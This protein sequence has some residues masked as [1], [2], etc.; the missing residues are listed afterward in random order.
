MIMSMSPSTQSVSIRTTIRLRTAVTA[1]AATLWLAG[2]ALPL[3]HPGTSVELPQSWNETS[4]SHTDALALEKEWWQRYGSDELVG[5]VDMALAGSPDL[6]VATERV[7]QAEIALRSAGAT[8]FPSID[9]TASTTGRNTQS[10]SSSITDKSSSLALGISY[11][12]DIWGTNLLNREAAHWQLT[13]TRYDY[14]ATRLS[15]VAGVVNAYT[16]L[17]SQRE[18]L[19]IARDNLDIAE[20]LFKI[21]EARFRFGAAS[22]L[23]VS[24]QHMTVLSQR[25]ALI[26]MEEQEKQYRRALAILLGQVPQQFDVAGDTIDPLDIPDISVVF[27]FELLTRR[28]DLAAEEARLAASDANIEIARAALFPLKFSL[29]A[30][31]GASSTDFALLGL[32][33]PITTS[34]LTISIIQNIF[35]GGRLRGQVETNESQRRQLVE[36]YR[37]TALTALKEVDDAYAAAAR[38]EAQEMSQ[39]AILAEAE[40]T[41]RLSE[42]RYREGSDTLTTLLDAQRSLF[43]VRDQLVQSRL[44]RLNASVDLYKALGGG[45]QAADLPGT[46]SR[47]EAVRDTSAG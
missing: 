26:P 14:E 19:A 2:C 21:V 40:R 37:K 10:S 28:P 8:L 29:G 23:D 7:V 6:A 45:W 41:L 27:P 24:R 11:E 12:I 18:R 36:T 25:D 13:A 1:L 17:L 16:Q 15:L 20:R 5:L 35:D 42:L 38:S 31:I 30:N 22:A 43:S 44:M 47:P 33:S 34:A 39:H 9:L 46:D 32:G 3:H 4:V